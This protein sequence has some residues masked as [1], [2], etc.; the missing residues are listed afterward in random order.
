MERIGYGWMH[1]LSRIS[2]PKFISKAGFGVIYLLLSRNSALTPQISGS[3]AS[4]SAWSAIRKTI[5]ESSSQFAKGSERLI[6]FILGE[7]L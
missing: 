5:K 1:D 3:V 7:H 2:A 4:A 6:L